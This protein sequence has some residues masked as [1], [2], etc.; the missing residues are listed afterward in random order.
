M[1]PAGIFAAG[2]ARRPGIA[3]TYASNSCLAFAMST[4]SGG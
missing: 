4:L 1:K 2:K 3:G